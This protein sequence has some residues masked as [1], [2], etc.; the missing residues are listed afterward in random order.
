M[1]IC[2][3]GC[4]RRDGGRGGP[5]AEPP[6]ETGEPE[7][8]TAELPP[9]ESA[10][11]AAVTA[12]T[13]PPARRSI[14]IQ[15]PRRG[16]VLVAAGVVAAFVLGAVAGQQIGDDSDLHR[17]CFRG[18]PWLNCGMPSFDRQGPPGFEQRGFGDR[19]PFRDGDDQP[20]F[21]G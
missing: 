11:A 17:E 2:L 21:H 1:M 14:T 8:P 20:R 3:D 12:E 18:A 15:A 10:E 6:A 13:Q 19:N 4:K 16:A 9:S 7:A 5:A